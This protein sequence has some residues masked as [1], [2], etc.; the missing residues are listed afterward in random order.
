MAEKIVMGYW[1]CPY[2]DSKG[3][4]GTTYDCPNCGRQRGKETKFYMKSGKVDYVPGHKVVGAD[5][6]CEYCGALN[7]AG[8]D[9]CENCGSRKDDSKDDYFSIGKK[10]EEKKKKEEQQRREDFHPTTTV[11]H[12]NNKKKFRLNLGVKLILAAL[13]FMGF[14]GIV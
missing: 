7:K 1:D 8:R 6:Y 12:T 14:S 9:T 5:W 4:P 13:A 2:C 10:E 3:I 11:S